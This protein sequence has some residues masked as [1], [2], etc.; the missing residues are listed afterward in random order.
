MGEEDAAIIAATWRH[1]G[2]I[3]GM[4]GSDCPQAFR[5]GWEAGR[6]WERQRLLSAVIE[7]RERGDHP[8]VI[9]AALIVALRAK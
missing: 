5:A 6:D 3:G 4:Y 7:C 8:S 2:G 1:P 9:V